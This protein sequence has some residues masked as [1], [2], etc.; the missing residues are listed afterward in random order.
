M[1]ELE[2]VVSVQ[3][4]I[5]VYLTKMSVKQLKELI[6]KKTMRVEKYQKGEGYQREKDA[7]RVQNISTFVTEYQGDE[8][9]WPILAGSAILN[10]PDKDDVSFDKG[11]LTIKK[12]AKINIV[13]GQ[14]RIFGLIES[15][16]E[17][18]E[19]PVSIVAGLDEF[20]EAAQFLI[21]NTK[22]VKVRPD[23]TLTVLHDINISETG[24]LIEKLKSALGVDEWQ[25]EATHLAIQLNNAASSPWKDLM[26]RPNET[27]NEE[28]KTRPRVDSC[29]S[30][31]FC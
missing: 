28:K 2:A 1:I 6:N 14:H 16:L 3:S 26:L 17:S 8:L 7:K 20:K 29:K 10:I 15:N 13:D 23:L 27:R 12:S 18:F 22:Q 30:S 11:K 9:I 25:L 21:I 19:L 4:G 31:I 24:V 5:P